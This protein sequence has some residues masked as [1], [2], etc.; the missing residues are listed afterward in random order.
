[1]SVVW[2]GGRHP[3]R[4]TVTSMSRMTSDTPTRVLMGPM[5]RRHGGTCQTYNVSCMIKLAYIPNVPLLT[6]ARGGAYTRGEWAAVPAPPPI[7][8]CEIASCEF[9]CPVAFAYPHPDPFRLRAA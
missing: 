4:R 9:A 3:A 5:I 7:P 8:A 1:M 6:P 2:I